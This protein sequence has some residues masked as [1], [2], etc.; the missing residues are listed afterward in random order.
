MV[1]EPFSLVAWAKP[2]ILGASQ[3][4]VSVALSGGASTNRHNLR[5]SA[6]G[7]FNALSQFGGTFDLA[8]TSTA[9]AV[10]VWGHGAAAFAATNSRTCWL[11]GSGKGTN[12][13]NVVGITL[14]R[15]TVGASYVSP[16]RGQYADAVIGPGAIYRAAITDDEA[17]LLGALRLH[18][19]LVRPWDLVACWDLGEQGVDCEPDYVGGY[20]LAITGA[21]AVDGPPG[22]IYPPAPDFVPWLLSQAG[23]PAAYYRLLQQHLGA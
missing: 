14:N 1:A 5:I 9:L 21:V 11:N 12:A 4:L 17:L 2:L 8:T 18:P 23:S 6:G 13:S 15:T 19:H 22:I 20:D 3:V 7:Q 10:D 16:F